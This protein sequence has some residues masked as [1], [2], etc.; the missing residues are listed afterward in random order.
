MESVVNDGSGRI[1]DCVFLTSTTEFSARDENREYV[2]F[3]FR[4]R[5]GD[6]VVSDGRLGSKSLDDR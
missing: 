4:M 3:L 5:R 6:V 1:V 2:K